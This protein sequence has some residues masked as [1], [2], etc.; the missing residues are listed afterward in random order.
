[1]VHQGQRESGEGEERVLMEPTATLKRH[2]WIGYDSAIS[3]SILSHF[4]LFSVSPTHLLP[5][6]SILYPNYQVI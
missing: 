5:L 2:K 1:M 6:H 4:L 3:L